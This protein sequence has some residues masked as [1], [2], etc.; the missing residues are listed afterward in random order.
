V[1]QEITFSYM[2]V[3][4]LPPSIYLNF[5]RLAFLFLHNREPEYSA[6]AA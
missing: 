4:R 2:F 1:T 5:Q 3:L 6:G